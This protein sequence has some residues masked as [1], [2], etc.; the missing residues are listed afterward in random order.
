MFVDRKFSNY[1]TKGNSFFQSSKCFR[2]NLVPFY[3][4]NL[5]FPE[6]LEQKFRK[7]ILLFLGYFKNIFYA[8]RPCLGNKMNTDDAHYKARPISICDFSKSRSARWLSKFY[9]DNLNRKFDFFRFF[10]LI[11]DFF[12]CRSSKKG[13]V[14]ANWQNVINNSKLWRIKNWLSLGFEF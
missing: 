5:S 3:E 7:K 10:I 8:F 9:L 4:I 14:K 11:L 2:I 13:F 1:I 12:H 6:N